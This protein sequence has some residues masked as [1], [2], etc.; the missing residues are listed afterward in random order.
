MRSVLGYMVY[1]AHF[2]LFLYFHVFVLNSVFIS[3]GYSVFGIVNQFLLI[4]PFVMEV[5]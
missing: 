1:A 2:F 4:L 3:I 5:S